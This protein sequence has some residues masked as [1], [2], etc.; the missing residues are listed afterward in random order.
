MPG[1]DVELTAVQEPIRVAI[2]PTIGP[3][4]LLRPRASKSN[5][6]VVRGADGRPC[7]SR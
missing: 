5:G 1:I 2:S 4:T 6:A 3:A 7:T